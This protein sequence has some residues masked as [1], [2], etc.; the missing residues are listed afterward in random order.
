LKEWPGWFHKCPT[1]GFVSFD[2]LAGI[3]LPANANMNILICMN[4][5][6]DKLTALLK[7]AGL[8][9][10][11]LAAAI[12]VSQATISRLASTKAYAGDVGVVARLA[13]H[14]KIP[15]TELLPDLHS[16]VTGESFFAFCP[17]PFC[18]ENEISR[19]VFLA[20][21]SFR[22]YPSDDFSETNFCSSCGTALCKE[23]P[24][25][26]RK[27]NKKFTLFCVR[28]GVRVCERPTPEEQ[29]KIRNMIED[30]IPF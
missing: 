2:I 3:F 10:A 23:C 5:F 14:F 22:E 17:N 27:F 26:Q 12:G 29:K 13:Q 30:D 6:G 21:S 16:D 20:W 15:L 7:G 8:T 18:Y 9:Q 24:S 28:C 19:D 25:C 11:Q 4:D 1:G